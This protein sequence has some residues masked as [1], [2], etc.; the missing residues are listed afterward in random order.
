M[1][2]SLKDP[3]AVPILTPL[4]SDKEVAI[5]VPWALAQIG[6][7]RAIGPLINSLSNEDPTIRVVVIRSLQQL[8]AREAIPALE[9]LLN[10]HGHSH[11]DD[12]ISVAE[13]AQQAIARIKFVAQ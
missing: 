12:L 6:D 11:V 7:R 10:D 9:L 3:K 13:A 5:G 2:G 8:H 1:L 4:L